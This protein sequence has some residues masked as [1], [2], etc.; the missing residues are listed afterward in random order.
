MATPLITG[1]HH[2]TAMASD[3]QQNLDFYAGLLGLRLVKKT[4]NFDAPDV[5]HLYY[6]DETGKA[7][8]IMTFFPFGASPYRGKQGIGQAATTSFSIPMAALD[9]WM[10]R[11]DHFG[12]NYKAPQAR[13]NEA[14]IYFEDPDGLGLELIANDDDMRPPFTYGHIPAEF[15]IRGF[16]GSELWETSYERTEALLTGQLGYTFIGEA[17][18]RRRYIPNSAATEGGHAGKYVDILWDANQ[19]YGQGGIGTVHHIAFDTPTDETQKAV[20]EVL[21]SRNFMP[22][23]VLDRQYFHSIYFRE[24]GGVLFEIATN[25]PGFT[26]DETVENLGTA[27]KLPPWEERRRNLIENHLQPISLEKAL[28]KYAQRTV[29]SE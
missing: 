6:G 22:T 8:S 9:F 18:V 12:I 15:A 10:N 24:P 13:F 2:V 3:P 26:L 23:Q 14:V 17:G 4:I 29:N 20:R 1:L 25:P 21:L 16:W 7:G 5:Y 28:E 11:F 27:L 19:R